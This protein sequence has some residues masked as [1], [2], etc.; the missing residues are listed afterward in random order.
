MVFSKVPYQ[1]KP[2]YPPKRK[3]SSVEDD[4][5]DPVTQDMDDVDSEGS[6]VDLYEEE[7]IDSLRAL[8]ASVDA[9]NT[10]ILTLQLPTQPS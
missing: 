10:K 4:S 5:K 2:Y 1:N 7:L 3:W 6:T 9:L 8:K